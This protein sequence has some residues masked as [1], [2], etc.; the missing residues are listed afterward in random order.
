MA[1]DGREPG[2]VRRRRRLGDRRPAADRR[3]A[4]QV[5]RERQTTRASSRRSSSPTSSST[6]PPGIISIKYG[7][8]GPEPRTVTACTT[9]AH[10]I[11]EAFR[12]IRH[13]DADGD[14]RRHGGDD[15]AARRR[16]LQRHARAVDA[17]RRPA[18]RQRPVRQRPRRLR[19]RRGRRA[20]S[21]SRSSSRRRSAARGSTPSSSA[22]AMTGD[23]HH[24]AAPRRGRR[25]PGARHEELPRRRRARAR[26]RS[27]TSTR[28]ARRRRS[29]TCAE[30]IADQEGLRRPREEARGVVDQ[31]DDRPP[32]RRGRRPRGRRSARSRSTHGVLPPTINYETPDPECDLDYVPNTA[33]EASVEYVLSNCFGFGGTNG[34]LI[35]K[36]MD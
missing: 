19:D 32:A 6:R 24:I 10:A 11:G 2:A 12:M 8:E 33:R 1:G 29:A 13:G 30:T 21:S 27:T 35:L 3:D 23:A 9:G 16:R 22:T 18:A 34:C 5:R 28:T 20:S 25:R 15:H 36:R 31:V 4:A 26:S 7:A 14:R 17:Q